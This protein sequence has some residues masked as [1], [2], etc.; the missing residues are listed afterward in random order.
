MVEL[1]SRTRGEESRRWLV[2][3]HGLFG[4]ADNLGGLARILEEHYRILL[5]DLRNHGRSPHA[6]GMTYADMAGDVLIAMDKE[7]I[8]NAIIFGHS[9]G[10]K[11]AMQLALMASNR[12]SDLIVGD[13][14]PV[15]YG[16]HHDRIL[17]GMQTV[18]AEAPQSRQEAQAILSEFESEPAVLSFLMT[19]WRKLESGNWGWRVNLPVIVSRYGDIASGSHGDAFSGPVLFLRGEHSDYVQ[20][21]H[22]D[23]ILALFPHATVKTIGGTGHWLHAEKPDMVARSILRFLEQAEQ[24]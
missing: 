20:T 21:D 19:N 16:G 5:L 18:A 3:L 6:E 4:S 2:M 8:E 12:V 17:E 15:Q 9:M 13:I 14:S 10:G 1:F 22:R 11:V 24:S 7:G 23:K